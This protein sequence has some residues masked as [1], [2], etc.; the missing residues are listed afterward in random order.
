MD[1]AVPRRRRR[2]AAESASAR[3][4]TQLG[5]RTLDIIR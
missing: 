2:R 3:A 5:A 1:D 4:R